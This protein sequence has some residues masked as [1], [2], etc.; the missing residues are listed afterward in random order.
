MRQISLA[1]ILLMVTTFTYAKS[2]AG[3]GALF[4]S[5]I[6]SSLGYAVGETTTNK[7]TI[8]KALRYAAEVT[9]KNLPMVIDRDTKWDAIKS[10]PGRKFTYLYTVTTYRADEIDKPNFYKMMEKNLLNSV[11]SSEDMKVFFRHD[12]TISYTYNGKFGKQFAKISITPKDCGY[13]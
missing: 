11:C 2:K 1:I 12:V 10:G 4:G 9:N 8:E 5:L 7:V 13:S 6:G 3:V